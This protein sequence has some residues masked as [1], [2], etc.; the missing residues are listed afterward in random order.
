MDAGPVR[1]TIRDMTAFQVGSEVEI[2]RDVPSDR[3]D[4]AESGGR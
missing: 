1:A 4:L 2:L 3:R